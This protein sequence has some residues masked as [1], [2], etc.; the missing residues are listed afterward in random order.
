MDIQYVNYEASYF[1]NEANTSCWE[2]ILSEYNDVRD[3]ACRPMNG[4][5]WMLG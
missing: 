3:E 5:G 2:W 4:S 1:F